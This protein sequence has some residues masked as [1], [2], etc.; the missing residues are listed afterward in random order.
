MDVDDCDCD[1]PS[2]AATDADDAMSRSAAIS[3][4]HDDVEVR[5]IVVW[6]EG[7]LFVLLEVA[8]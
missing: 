4:A 8:H 3:A 7:A 2:P 1:P 6:Y 5:D